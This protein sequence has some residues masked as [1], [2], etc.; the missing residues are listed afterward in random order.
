MRVARAHPLLGWLRLDGRTYSR[1]LDQSL[2]ERDRCRAALWLKV[3]SR[4]KPNGADHFN[5]AEGEIIF[6]K[7][8]K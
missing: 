6:L 7:V 1:T 3:P 5:S 2:R 4:A 8:K